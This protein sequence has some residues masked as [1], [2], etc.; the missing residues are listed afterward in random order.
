MNFDLNLAYLK[1]FF[2]AVNEEAA[3]DEIPNKEGESTF[4]RKGNFYGGVHLG[5]KLMYSDI[6]LK[7]LTPEKFQALLK[8]QL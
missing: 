6:L 5:K 3:V 2:G 1:E 7:T 8:K 4:L